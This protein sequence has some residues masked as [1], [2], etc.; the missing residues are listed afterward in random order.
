MIVKQT[1]ITIDSEGKMFKDITFDI[2]RVLTDWK[3]QDGIVTVYS[4]HTTSCVKILENELLSL[5][6]I[7]LHLEGLAPE[8]YEYLHDNIDLRNVPPEERINGV[9]HV[10]SLYFPHSVQ[11]P[12]F[13]GKLLMGEWQTIFLVDLDGPRERKLQVIFTGTKGD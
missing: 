7:K 6:D 12:V 4:L 2:R 5:A 11:I 8:G 13:E 10:R 3:A 9:A 1:T